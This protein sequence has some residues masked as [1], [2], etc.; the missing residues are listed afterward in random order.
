MNALLLCRLA[1]RN[2]F[3]NAR[4]SL[5]TGSVV[6]FGVF[7]LIFARGFID[8]LQYG[9]ER[10]Q[11]DASCAHLRV[12]PKGADDTGFD[13]PLTPRLDDVGPIL[14]A[15]QHATGAEAATPRIRF[16]AE[17]TDGRDSVRVVA[18]GAD[19]DRD[20]KVFTMGVDPRLVA[21]DP[22]GIL[23]GSGLM[24]LFGKGPANVGDAF[25][26]VARTPAGA[27]SALDFLV[28][29]IINTGNPAVDNLQVVIPIATA[30]TLLAL[31]P[32]EATEVAVRLHSQRSTG[33][34]TAALLRTVPPA[35][36]VRTWMDATEDI[37]N[38]MRIRRRGM[39]I[40][41]SVIMAIAAAGIANTVLMSV[42]E[43]FREIGTLMA[44]G[45]PAGSV[46][47]LFFLEGVGIGLMGSA[48]G[49]IA[50]GSLVYYFE[51]HGIDFSRFTSSPDSV[52]PMATIIYTELTSTGLLWSG[53]FGLLIASLA[54]IWPAWRAA[55]LEPVEALR[56]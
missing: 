27:I 23:I 52:Y 42:F 31:G 50:G 3:R 32:A 38:L 53:G 29:G 26:L 44:F 55:K 6:F 36:E 28:K 35:I 10:A 8:G 9:S 56:A 25:T 20:G 51:R 34:A 18:I 13:L 4:R 24:T 16:S 45:Y 19:L 15:A 12:M 1:L 17:L 21:G 14:A 22:P 47:L 40:T 39:M 46:R 41:V 48:A 49:V 11:I 54:T 30:R 43:R 7:V 2:V 5:L 37:R 33:A